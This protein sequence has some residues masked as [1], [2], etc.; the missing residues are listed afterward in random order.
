[1]SQ[2][3]YQNAYDEN[4]RRIHISEVDTATHRGRVFQCISCG[5]D[6]IAK[7]GK[8]EKAHAKA[9]HFAHKQK[10]ECSEETYLHK[11]GKIRFQERFE[12]GEPIELRYPTIKACANSKTCVFYREEFCT[13]EK[14]ESFNI[15]DWYDTCTIEKEYNGYR[16]DLLLESSGHKEREPLFIE[17]V[18]SHKCSPK[19]LESKNKIIEID[20]NNEFQLEKTIKGV[21]RQKDGVRLYNFVKK[22][23]GTWSQGSRDLEHFILYSSGKAFVNSVTCEEALNLHTPNAE[24]EYIIDQPWRNL[25]WH[26]TTYNIGFLLASD[27]G[28]NVQN[29]AFCKYHSIDDGGPFASHRIYCHV[30]AKQ[31]KA[32]HPQQ[33]DAK[34]CE[35]FRKNREGI[36]EMRKLLHHR[37]KYWK[38][39]LKQ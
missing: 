25:I 39:P 13:I 12:S 7:I 27:E 22:I 28:C 14:E 11:L 29:C 26:F 34:M 20:V 30:L 6:L 33:T 36:V 35:A 19:K 17:I 18:Y 2:V 9:P 5:K 31:Y 23:T 16:A 4:G 10:C 32:C 1:M 8:Q 3:T 21:F 15:R 24:V 38:L 37:I